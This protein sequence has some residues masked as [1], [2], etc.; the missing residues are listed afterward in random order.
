MK[1]DYFD[2]SGPAQPRRPPPTVTLE[3]PLP[4]GRSILWYPADQPTRGGAGGAG[5]GAERGGYPVFFEQAAINAVRA[6]LESAPDQ[7]LIGFLA[8]D[9]YRCPDTD[10]VY[11]VIDG[12]LR[13]RHPVVNHDPKPTFQ[14]V[15]GRLQHE[16]RQM[17][18]RLVG[19]YRAEPGDDL[20]PNVWDIAVHEAYFAEPWQVV[21]VMRS[22][23]FKPRGGIYRAKAGFTWGSR[24]IP[25][26]E[27]LDHQPRRSAG[28]KRTR[29][30][31]KNYHTNEVV[32]AADERR[33]RLTSRPSGATAAPVPP[34]PPPATARP[35]LELVREPRPQPESVSLPATA[36]SPAP[37]PAARRPARRDD[38]LI[39]VQPKRTRH[40]WRLAMGVGLIGLGFAAVVGG[41]LLFGG[42]PAAGGAPADDPDSARLARLDRLSDTLTAA[43]RN[44][45][46]REGLYRDGLLGCAGLDRGRAA[47]D[48]LWTEYEALRSGIAGSL[49]I[50]RAE[51]EGR[52]SAGV[53][54]LRRRFAT[55]GCPSP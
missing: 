49:D 54:S 44:Y 29:L 48:T 53:G 19:W 1:F 11:L 20:Q 45:E 50:A 31:W 27:T 32:I 14:K 10:V 2:S 5:G 42:G 17:Q 21:V 51:R 12:I 36:P 30:T 26:Y 39:P 22:D 28:G 38:S 23:R 18:A 46:E 24:P 4:L 37:P 8:G 13:C 52:L 16:V 6:H 25:F 35:T 41:L 40:R 33:T 47:V 55:S 9:L 3:A 15:W 34:T 7:P 43:V